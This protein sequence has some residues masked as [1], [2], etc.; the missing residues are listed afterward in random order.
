MINGKE[1]SEESEYI[2]PPLGIHKNDIPQ[3]DNSRTK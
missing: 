2:N 1:I 3:K